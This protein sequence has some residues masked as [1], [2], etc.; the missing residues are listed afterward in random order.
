[1]RT[2]P[3]VAALVL[4]A[5]TTLLATDILSEGGDHGRTGW[6]KDEQLC[7]LANVSSTTLVGKL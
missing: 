4:T 6:V 1:M 5:G 2:R 7:S 3:I